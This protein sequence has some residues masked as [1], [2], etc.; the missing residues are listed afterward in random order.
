MRTPGVHATPRASRDAIR[1]GRLRI[2]LLLACL[3]PVARAHATVADDLCAP[4]VDPCLVNTTI[5]VTAGSTIDLGA[6][7]LV[8]GGSAR[9][10]FSSGPTTLRAGSLRL[11]PG[12]R[13]TGATNGAA[14]RIGVDLL[15]D[16]EMQA[17]GSL[18]ARVELSNA[19]EGGE[20]R[21]YLGGTARL[22]GDVVANATSN[23]GFGG[24]LEIAA[25]GD[26]LAGGG[27]LVLRGGSLA[28]GGTVLLSAAGRAALGA[29]VDVTG[30][31]FG[32]GDIDV[33]AGSDLAVSAPLDL[34]GGGLYG[35]G[36]ALTLT[37]Q[38][39]SLQI[40]GAITGTAAGDSSE[41][42]GVGADVLLGAG[43]GV[44]VSAPMTI[45]GAIPDGGG[46]VLVV[47]AGTNAVLSA[48]ILAGASG[49]DSCGGDVD[50]VAGRDVTLGRVDLSAGGCGGGFLGIEALG[51]ATLN[52]LITADGA[53]SFGSG[54]TVVVEATTVNVT[55][56]VR[57][58]AP[59][60]G[61]GGSVDVSGCTVTVGATGDLRS[62]GIAALTR[63]SA[64]GL[65][66][67]AGRLAATGGQN[68]I[69]Y[70]DPGTP[71][72]VTGVVTPTAAPVL[73]PALP[74]CP[75]SGTVCGDGMPAGSEQ[76]DDANTLACDG[77]S[78]TCRI[79]ACG[80][81]RIE[82][83][84]ECD[85][86]PQTGLPGST[87]DATC[88]V[89]PASG[90]VQWIPGGR[91]RNACV[92]E[93]AVRNPNAPTEDGFPSTVQR[94]IDGD[95]ACDGDGASDGT[96]HFE[97]AGCLAVDDP[98]LPT[99]QPTGVA[100]V[101]LK[102]PNPLKVTAPADVA[103]AAALVQAIGAL[104]ITLKGGTTVIVPGATVF[105]RDRCSAPVT[106]AVPHPVGAS[107]SVSLEVAAQ[108]STGGRMRRNAIQLVCDPNLAVCGNGAT[109]IGE[110]CDDGNTNACD[111]CS[112]A[113]RPESCGDGLPACGE[114][115]DDGPANGTPESECT[116]TC[117]FVVPPLR[118]PGG[119]SKATDCQLETAIDLASPAVDRKGLPAAKQEC[120][121]GDPGCD[122]D[123]AAGSCG[124]AAWACVAGADA[125][126]GCAAD[127][128]AS[129]EVRR[130]T[131]RDA[132]ALAA[133]RAELVATLGAYQP[134][135]PG[136]V[137]SGR[138]IL[139]VPAD[140]RWAKVQLQTRNAAQRAD[141][142]TLRLRCLPQ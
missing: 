101:S 21:A 85:D 99:C 98:R 15:G 124:F 131:T 8:L 128:V 28:G 9:L 66:T 18:R 110:Q 27:S 80:N 125:R 51:A 16:L 31:E 142:D 132:G 55:A 72:V 75:P 111:G 30:G 53:T 60:G 63:L 69:A 23:D 134:T 17:A 44:T 106:I 95:P 116:A 24:L 102:A 137:C 129:L 114:Q 135:G 20:L 70:R 127:H 46:G 35:D 86:G 13:I 126:L 19:T 52:G 84:E 41:G 96:C 50:I 4:A 89:I 91:S 92:F 11:Q 120:T 26:V 14:S 108:S 113:C 37:A 76:C 29:R 47:E 107:G 48:N 5:S 59:D 94:C 6:R 115:C 58:T 33:E 25:A 139:R 121:D 112:P 10:L 34:N 42:G 118:I 130:P 62:N 104:G 2:L 93:W 43:Q 3:A 119:G 54:G 57:A 122:R 117:T 22:D 7:A 100:D 68:V 109:E 133:L 97:V 123:P 103:R 39:G 78:A 45:T 71:P 138:M 87:C 61:F 65:A 79:E 77:C 88:H 83:D 81:G 38:R 136:E 64:S 40:T 36:G 105:G 140:R 74:P 49:V 73:N 12:A 67:I 32:G 56:V 82:C 1:G 90:G 141:T